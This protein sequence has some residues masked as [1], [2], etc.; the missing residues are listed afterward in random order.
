MKKNVLS[1]NKV[2]G[3]KGFYTAL[4]ISAAMIGTAC[5]F[6]YNQGEKLADNSF[7][8]QEAPAVHEASVEKTT[9]VAVDKKA[10]DIPKPTTSVYT[11]VTVPQT[12]EAVIVQAEVPHDDDFIAEYTEYVAEGIPEDAYVAGTQEIEETEA[13]MKTNDAVPEISG[14]PLADISNII[15]PFSGS[16][17]VR[18][19][20]TGSW[21]THNGTD[22]AAEV[23]TEVYAV[24]G[25]EIA[26]VKRDPLWG[27]TVVIDCQNGFTIRYCSLG[28]NLA[29]QNGDRVSK[30]DLLGF[31]GQSADIESTLE[32]HLHI[33]ITHNGSY[34][35]P[36]SL[37][38]N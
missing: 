23:G 26:S 28:D 19:E 9:E 25:G 2:K 18:N 33:E 35:D 10:E 30:G 37:F 31:V 34:V 11:A 27:V 14:A 20:T 4:G 1:D 32:P 6:A 24:A 17:L 3:S 36:L 12:T 7:T 21:Q 22:F 16:E 29:V 38:G 5:V 13:V 8:I 15:N